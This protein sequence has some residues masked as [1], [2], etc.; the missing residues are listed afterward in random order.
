[1]R[2]ACAALLKSRDEDTITSIATAPASF[3]LTGM[4]LDTCP[5]PQPSAA[6]AA[7]T[8]RRGKSPRLCDF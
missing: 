8:D 2:G 5:G 3:D 1:M 4:P 7:G 6:A